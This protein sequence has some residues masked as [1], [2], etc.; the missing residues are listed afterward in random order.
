MGRRAADFSPEG[1]LLAR[2][3]WVDPDPERSSQV[4]AIL[5]KGIDWDYLIWAAQAHGVMPLL[6]RLVN[7]IGPEGGVPGPAL[8][9]LRQQFHANALRNLFFTGELVKVLDLLEANSIPA[10]PFKGPTLAA[11]AYGNLALRQFNDLDL[12][13]RKRDIPRA[14]TL[15]SGLGYRSQLSLRPDQEASYLE[16]IGQLPLVQNGGPGLIELHSTLLPRNFCFSLAAEGLWNRLERMD[17][18][19]KQV[20]TLSPE[21]LLLVLCAHGAKHLWTCL[22]WI[23]DLARLIQ[24]RPGLN[25]ARVQELAGRL[26]ARRILALGLYL[27][28]DLLRANLPEDVWRAVQSDRMVRSLAAWVYRQVFR[29]NEGVP[30]GW[31]SSLFHLWIREHLRDG[32]RY[33]LSLAL[34]PTRADWEF[35]PLRR[36]CSFL[37]FLLRPLRLGV[38]YGSNLWRRTGESTG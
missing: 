2:A 5:R 32:V 25:W 12:L 31:Q 21:D 38:K 3:A 13:L 24:A 26:R 37:Y 36:S 10:V 20:R 7:R 16:S 6:Y 9:Q 4:Q 17:L 18:A 35:L 34:V 28:R 11:S 1:E 27:A 19:G 22:G 33:S 30:G 15:L 23:C 14:R 8:E 29:R